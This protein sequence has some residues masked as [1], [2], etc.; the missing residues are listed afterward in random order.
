MKRKGYSLDEIAVQTGGTTVEVQESLFRFDSYSAA[1]STEEVDLA[2]N[3]VLIQNARNVGKAL[4]KGMTAQ[5]TE[6]IRVGKNK[7]TGEDRYRTV[8]RPDHATQLSAIDK[9]VA[10]SSMSR[11][12]TSGVAVNVNQ[13][14]NSASSTVTGS[15]SPYSFEERVRKIKEARGESVEED[16]VD[17]SDLQEQSV[18]EEL[19]GIG[20]D[21]SDDDDEDDDEDD[22]E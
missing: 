7:K 11:P 22:E 12:K 18:E 14:F 4:T 20:I 17:A 16:V 8:K 2:I 21:L 5:I 13:Q 6:R 10:L 15:A 3:D 19:E 9:F 1:V